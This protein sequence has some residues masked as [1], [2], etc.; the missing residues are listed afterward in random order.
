MTESRQRAEKLIQRL[1]EAEKAITCGPT[2]SKLYNEYHAGRF[3]RT[4]DICKKYVP[5]R[6]SVV[7]DVGRGRLTRL[8]SSHYNN[9][10]SMGF[11]PGTDDG[12]H[13]EQEPMPEIPHIV[14]DLNDSGSTELY[15]EYYDHFDLIV[16]GDTIEHLYTAPE[17][18][19]LMLSCML[20]PKGKIVVT[21]P[22]AVSLR[23]RIVMFFG[24]NPFERIRYY[25]GNPGHYREY[26]KKELEQMGAAAGL[27]VKE[28]YTVN[29]YNSWSLKRVL[30]S[31][32]T[33]LPQF[34]DSL[35][36]VFEKPAP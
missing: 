6:N 35:V 21:T 12:G 9:V 18:S 3:I 20:K 29:F 5:D 17:F 27:D 36:A 33:A 2:S 8:I 7:L 15:P 14:F 34:R 25:K 28:C 11:E 24:G 30:A 26:R 31:P 10:W 4:L 13:R 19:L 32:F 23:N 1:T 16:F 22:N